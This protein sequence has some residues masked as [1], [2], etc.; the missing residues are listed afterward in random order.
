MKTSSTFLALA[1]TLAFLSCASYTVHQV[2][3]QPI[4]QYSITAQI[5]SDLD[6]ALEIY[7]NARK[8]KTV[9]DTKPSY[10]RGYLAISF[11]FFNR[12]DN[13][14][15]LDPTGIVALGDDGTVYQPIPAAQVAE[16]LLRSTTG[17]YFAGGL[18][19]AGSSKGA[20][21]KIRMDFQS[22][23]LKAHKIFGHAK[24]QG[25]LFFPGES[26]LNKII[27]SGVV[28]EKGEEEVGSTDVP[29]HYRFPLTKEDQ[30][31]SPFSR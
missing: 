13:T 18:I 4:E 5:D 12:G 10:E 9:F 6:V 3:I 7:D 2:P 25:I 29:I 16:Q 31:R 17:R 11:F 27:I 30:T 21:E 20:N 8:Y 23:E 19:A 22:K 26:K 28:R 1:M 24:T 14:F 15:D